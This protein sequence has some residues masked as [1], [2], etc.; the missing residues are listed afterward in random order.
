MPLFYFDVVDDGEPSVPD[1]IGTDLK[2][3]SVI[4]AEA[5]SLISTI[6]RDRLPDGLER[7]FSVSVRDSA[8]L[9]VF[10]A[11]LSLKSNWV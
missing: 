7:R 6:A 5:Q 11:D 10:E 1:V 9:V 2:D 3:R 8:S 4:P